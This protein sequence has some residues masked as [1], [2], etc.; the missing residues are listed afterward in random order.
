M[1]NIHTTVK[2]SYQ[3]KMALC[4][5][6]CFSFNFGFTGYRKEFHWIYDIIY[7]IY[8]GGRQIEINCKSFDKIFSLALHTLQCAEQKRNKMWNIQ[9]GIFSNTANIL[10]RTPQT[11]FQRL[12]MF[13]LRIF[14]IT[15]NS[16]HI[17]LIELWKNGHSV[18]LPR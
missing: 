2:Y 9:R 10:T 11:L 6:C 12:S 1:E 18:Y 17:R 15:S 8:P 3:P 7:Q 14:S 4:L 13:Q 16:K 5:F